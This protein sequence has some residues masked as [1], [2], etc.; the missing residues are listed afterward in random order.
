MSTMQRKGTGGFPRVGPGFGRLSAVL[1]FIAS[2]GMMSTA[3]ATLCVVPDDGTGTAQLPP[4]CTEG[5]LSPTDVHTIIA[6]LPP[7]TEILLDA[8]HSR[9]GV[10]TTTPGGTLGGEIE[11]FSSELHLQMT[12]TGDLT[13]FARTLVVSALCETHT[14]PRT[15]GDAVQDFDTEMV[16]LQGEIFGDPDFDLLRVRA[17]TGFGLPSPGHTTLTRLPSGDFN[18]DSFFDIAYEIEFVGAP[19][20]QLGG[21]SGITTGTVRMQAGSPP[22][23][24]LATCISMN[25][26]DPVSHIEFGNGPAVPQLPPGFFDPGSDPFIGPVE[27]QGVPIDPANMGNTDTLVQRAR[28][29]NVPNP[30]DVDTIPIEIVQL[31][32]TSAAPIPVTYGGTLTELWDLQVQLSPP[33]T[34]SSTGQMTVQRTH[35]NGG[36]FDSFFDIWVDLTFVRQSDGAT[37]LL[38]GLGPITLSHQLGHWVGSL[39]PSLGVL[40]PPG[41]TFFPGV[42]EDPTGTQSTQAFDPTSN[43]LPPSIKHIVYP[44]K[45]VCTYQIVCVSGDCSSCPAASAGF[46]QGAGCPNGT[47]GGLSGL[48]S[49][50]GTGINA[51]CIEFGAFTCG[52][53]IG[54]PPCPPIEDC[55]CQPD[56]LGACCL[57]DGTCSQTTQADCAG[58]WQ[59]AGTT[60]GQFGACCFADGTCGM[61]YEACC[62]G[63]WTGGDCQTPQACCLNGTCVDMAPLCCEL[64]GG[65]VQPAGESCTGTT[66]ACCIADPIGGISCQDVDPTCCDD[67]GGTSQ[68]AGTTCVDN[69]GNGVADACETTPVCPLPGNNQLCATLQGTDCVSGGAADEGCIPLSLTVNAAGQLVADQCNCITPNTLCGPIDATPIPGTT[70]FTLSC[71]NACP[72]PA[73]DCVVHIDGLSTGQAVIDSG[74]VNA[75]QTVTCGC[76]SPPVCQPDATGTGCDPV[77]C[78]DPNQICQPRMISVFGT[79]FGSVPPLSCMTD[80]DCFGVICEKGSHVADCDCINQGDCHVEFDPA[81]QAPVCVGTCPPG[82]DCA[83]FGDDLDGD[84]VR[85]T[86][87]C[88]CVTP[89][90]CQPN[91]AGTACEPYACPDDP[92]GITQDCLPQCVT[93]DPLTGQTIVTACNCTVKDDCHVS[94]PAPGVVASGADP[95]VVTDTGGTVSLPPAGC[96]YLSPEDVHKIIDGL[97]AGTT[98]EFDAS[99][100]RFI[101]ELQTP[102][103]NLGGEI[104]LFGSNLTMQLTGTGDLAGFSRVLA[105]PVQCEVHTGPRT[106]GDAVQDF[107]TE[108]VQLQGALFGDP[109]FCV[110]NITG[111]SGN[112]LPSPGHTTLTRLPSGDFNVDS[113]FDIDYRI[114]FQGCPGSVLD[115]LSGSTTATIKMST[116]AGPTC[117]G[118]CPVGETCN[119]VRTLNADGTIN[120]CCECVPV[121]QICQPNATGTGCEP[122]TC[123]DSAQ[124]CQPTLVSIIGACAD[125][126]APCQTD[127]DCMGIACLKTTTVDVCDCIG[128]GDCHVEVDPLTLAPSCVGTCPPGQDCALFGEDLDGDGQR[129]RF[130]CDCV[131]PPACKPNADGSACDPYACPADA[132]GV[133]GKCS[134]KCMHFDPTTGVTTATEC[135]CVGPN[136]CHAEAP[137]VA[138]NVAA[139]LDP[140]CVVVD[141]GSGTVTLPPAGCPYLSP[142]DVHEIIAGL[143]AGTKLELG[144]SHEKFQVQ[145]TVP[146]GTLGGEIEQFGSILRLSVNGTGALGT[147]SRTLFV[148][149]NCEAHTGPRTPGDAVQSFPNDMFRLQGE[150]FGDPDFCTLRITGGTDNG[151]PSPGHTTLTRL[152]SG[153]FNVD[154]F[155]D[156]EYRIDFAGCPGSVLAGMSGS[157]TDTIHMAAGTGPSCVGACPPGSDCVET[158]T[159]N[160]DGTIDLCCSCEACVVVDPPDLEPVP[161]NKNRFISFS[162][163]NPGRQTALRVTMVNLPGAYNVWNGHQMWV[164]G[165]TTVT[166]LPSSAGAVPLPAFQAGTLSCQRECRDWSTVRVLNVFH[167]SIIPGARYVVQAIDCDCDPADETRYSAP[168]P[169]ATAKHG[170]VVGPFLLGAWTA[171]DGSVDVATDVVSV[172]DKFGAAPT[173]PSK[174]WADLEP[175]CIDRKINITDVVI[176]LDAFGGALYPFAPSAN[177]PCLAIC[178]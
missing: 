133:E 77:V 97:P 138:G 156:I 110:L 81:S 103:G 147:F 11:Q 160:S 127:A 71:Q 98:I 104:E 94:L 6:G 112:G 149:V 99:H 100:D 91:A 108:M 78:P 35:A 2:L 37:R 86:F 125:N 136:E 5:Y 51:C 21:L 53:P 61:A 155:F 32:L 90:A 31:S 8:S 33:L 9:F 140:A 23:D 69:D 171:P 143:P 85:D 107:D 83:L 68:G 16:Q 45:N 24:W 55:V 162:P 174:V 65:I 173:A 95:C 170:D 145:S 10:P 56:P 135:D 62:D 115:G 73:Q 165:P 101:T 42:S 3:F 74:A 4:V 63:T 106:P 119:E 114:D 102:G 82:M 153:N 57:N 111:G 116:G 19:G 29:P 164:N 44:P 169:L 20:G 80:A 66:E 89:P 64:Q 28:N 123:A 152:P 96:A 18:V 122:V 161:V 142:D 17:G 141:N 146:G 128:Q 144:A 58:T 15:P 137:T 118:Q 134:P 130:W 34:S 22:A 43:D 76:A 148:P 167:E 121:P 168:L 59:G 41:A 50:C 25:P 27:L 46:C 92:T 72:N 124:I 151:M 129:D 60:C 117:K 52:A 131:D 175:A 13:G 126:G 154:S 139:L 39:D 40:H 30:G 75:G 48:T 172:L 105:I 88:D 67:L 7:G 12:G 93:Y 163:T 70:I 132:T 36:T 54:A 158:R 176:I 159:V 177:D 1:G 47:C 150:L 26:T 84:G 120:L 113:F 79:C 157:T 38:T 109:D 166:E 178:P 49:T 87:W 14:G